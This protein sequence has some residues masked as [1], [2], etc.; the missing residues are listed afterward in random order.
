MGR[1]ETARKTFCGIEAV[2]DESR[3]GNCRDET[4]DQTTASCETVVGESVTVAQ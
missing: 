1:V 2:R 4:E 3:D